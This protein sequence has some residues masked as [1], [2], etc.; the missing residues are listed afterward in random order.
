MS[1]NDMVMVPRELAE[2]F[3]RSASPPPTWAVEKLRAILDAPTDHHA[4]PVALPAR[5]RSDPFAYDQGGNARAD[6]WNACLDEIARLGPLYSRPV[7]GE[8]VAWVSKDALMCLP[9]HGRLYA[10]FKAFDGAVPLYTR[11]GPGEVERLREGRKLLLED[12]DR[13]DATV[14]ELRA[15][16]AERDALLRKIE[17]YHWANVDPEE[18]ARTRAELRDM[19]SASAEPELNP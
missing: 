11:A 16:L 5:K 19:L 13:R 9:T 1:K 4:E 17:G 18:R 6:G 15:Q 7:Q 12:L 3:D 10:H 14:A 2:T 8:P